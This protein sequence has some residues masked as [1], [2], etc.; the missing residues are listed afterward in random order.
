MM[1]ERECSRRRTN[2]NPCPAR[3]GATP[4]ATTLLTRGAVELADATNRS[5]DFK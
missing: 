4:C 2:E 3:N 1:P 5:Y